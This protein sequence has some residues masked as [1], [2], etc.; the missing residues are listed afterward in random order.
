MRHPDDGLFDT[1]LA[2]LL[3]QRIEQRDEAIPALEREALLADVL[4]VQIALEP[5]GRGQL[6]ENVLLL[7]GAEAKLHPRRLKLILQPQPLIAVRNMRELGA[8]GVGINEF[9]GGAECP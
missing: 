8:D 1:R 7:R 9:E 2:R 3:Y 4:G 6:P 5:L